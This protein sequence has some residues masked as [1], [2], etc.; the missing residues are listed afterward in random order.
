[1]LPSELE[2][3]KEQLLAEFS[4][5]QSPTR[6]RDEAIAALSED[7]LKFAARSGVSP[8]NYLGAK[9][10]SGLGRGI[11]PEAKEQPPATKLKDE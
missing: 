2:R 5:M 9:Q 6:A 11:D 7:E 1:M 10:S 4:A 3:L 8:E